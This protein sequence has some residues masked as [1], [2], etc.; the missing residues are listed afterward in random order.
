MSTESILNLPANHGARSTNLP[1]Y[2]ASLDNKLGER[3]RKIFEEYSGLAPDEVEPHV[4]EVRKLAW[5]VF[6]WPCIGEFWFLELGLT[7]HP[8]YDNILHTL[9]DTSLQSPKL[10]DLGTCLGQDLRELAY[11]GVPINSLY[12][13]DLVPGFEAAA[14][15]L[16]RDSDRFGPSNFITSNIFSENIDDGLVKTRG[17]WDIIHATMFLHIWSLEDQEKAC[18]NI[19]KLLSEKPGSMVIGTQTGSVKPS[20]FTLRPPLCEPG[21]HKVVYR[22][23]KDTMSDMW[24]RAGNKLGVKIEVRTD[25]D[26]EERAAREKG[27]LEKGPEWE[28]KQRFF[29]GEDERRVFFTIIRL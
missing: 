21:E 13:A 29:T 17:T 28:A 9:K 18:E 1:W 25:Y 16:F 15:K 22:H 5:S 23:S 12:G 10:L 27:R 7:R 6:P 26:E 3:T 14:Y 2:V 4:Y 8:E 20:E 11:N 19:L 24:T